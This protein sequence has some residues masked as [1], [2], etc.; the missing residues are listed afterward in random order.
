LKQRVREHG[1]KYFFAI[2]R[3]AS[4]TI[5]HNLLN[6]Y[7]KFSVEDGIDS[8]EIR[9]AHTTHPSVSEPLKLDDMEMSRLV[10]ES[11]LTEELR[12]IMRIRFDH[13]DAYL[14]FHGGV[15]FLV[16]LDV[17]NVSVSFDI[18]GAQDKLDELTVNEFPGENLT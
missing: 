10:V 3:G 16:A 7:H 15:L 13:H 14:D 8:Y 5:V 12:E 18:E 1:H 6:D 4:N 9:I 17:C 11:L 2:A